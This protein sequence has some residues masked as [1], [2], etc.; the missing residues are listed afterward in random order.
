MDN[1]I[2]EIIT[3]E[4]EELEKHYKYEIWNYGNSVAHLEEKL[5]WDEQE[6]DI[7][8]K[9]SED[10]ILNIKEVISEDKKKLK[11]YENKLIDCNKVLKY[12]KE[13]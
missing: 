10:V 8:E 6:T 3:R 5:R 2:K 13:V 1:K 11:Q 7:D 9:Y 12:L 4:F